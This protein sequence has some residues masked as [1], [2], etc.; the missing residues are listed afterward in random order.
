MEAPPAS[1]T[2]GP[3]AGSIPTPTHQL[4]RILGTRSA[5]R[6]LGW[7]AAVDG[8]GVSRF[9][10]ICETYDR[11]DLP[12]MQCWK[13]ALPH[14]AIDWALK[15]A[16]LD[17]EVMKAKL[18]HHHPTVRA[19]S[20]TARS[21]A[22]YGLTVPQRFIAPLMV[23]WN[24]TRACNLSCQHCYENARSKPERDELTL[25]EKMGVVDQLASA[26]VPFLAVAGGEP[27]VCKDFWPVVEYANKRGIHLTVATNGTL[28]TPAVAERLVASGVKYVEVSIDSLHPEEHDVFR[29]RPGSWAKSIEGIRNLVHAGMRTGLAMC[30]TRKTVG[31]VDEAV[32]LAIDLGCK[33]FSHFNFIPAGRGREIADE[34]L[35]PRQREW[36]IQRLAWHLQEGKINVISTAPQFGRAC[37]V[38]GSPDGVFAVGHAG[39]GMGKQTLVLA[40]Y[41][42][43]CGAGRCYCAI[44]PNGDVT[45]C[46]YIPSRI[47]GNLR[48]QRL[49]NIWDCDLFSVLSDRTDRGGH[50]RSCDFQ[51]YCGGCRARALAYT[52]DI[53]E[54]DP[55]CIYN[56]A[57]PNVPAQHWA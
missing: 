49:H 31:T 17:K 10:Q 2:C 42:G 55:G 24:I 50:C 1:P 54:G 27:L 19:L 32:Q 26:G 25:G 48:S 51:A 20:M 18:F 30:F 8:N 15:R 52:G 35:T 47:I 53:K 36:L 14:L 6:V 33:T 39:K 28:L 21:I 7:L 57:A 4:E 16:R 34:D 3:R 11:P 12:S 5:Q 38:Y 29:G 56:R 9:E 44:Q 22:H 46:V 37:I 41:V 13:W 40:R 45:P 43:G 23:V